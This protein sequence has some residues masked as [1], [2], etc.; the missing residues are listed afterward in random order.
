MR[1]PYTEQALFWKSNV[2]CL[3]SIKFQAKNLLFALQ[4]TCRCFYTRAFWLCVVHT[5]NKRFGGKVLFLVCK[6]KSSKH[7]IYFLAFSQH[8][9]ALTRVHSGC[10]WF[11]HI[12]SAFTEEY[13]FL[14]VQRKILNTD[15]IWPSARMLVLFHIGT[16]AVDGS[17]TE[18]AL[19]WRSNI[20]CFYRDKCLT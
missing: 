1:G 9:S 12:T 11:S 2:S 15:S 14:F 18:Q 3:Y 7:K 17:Y 6:A 10:A 16:L 8:V 4:F 5:M 13:C 19:S 20:S